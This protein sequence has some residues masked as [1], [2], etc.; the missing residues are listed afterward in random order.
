RGRTAAHVFHGHEREAEAHH[1]V[2]V[3][4]GRDAA[5]V[6]VDVGARAGDGDVADAAL[7]LEGE[8]AGRGARAEVAVPVDRD[9][10]DGIVVP[11]VPA[12]GVL[13]PGQ[14]DLSGL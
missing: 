6:V 12:V 11:E 13:L 7:D 1:D 14:P 5:D 9:H 4:G 8:A 10:P 3:P 2:A